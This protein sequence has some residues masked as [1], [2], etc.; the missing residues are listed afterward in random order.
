[1]VYY[2]VNNIKAQKF[3]MTLIFE[4]HLKITL[5]TVFV[6]AARAELAAV[7]AK[8]RDG[9]MAL[10][11]MKASAPSVDPMSAQIASKAGHDQAALAS[12]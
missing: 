8:A 12:A 3:L 6:K 2:F 1:M 5:A 11:T 10:A 9:H 4:Q 7:A